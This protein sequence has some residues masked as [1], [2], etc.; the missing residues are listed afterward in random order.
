MSYEKF[1]CEIYIEYSIYYKR[2]NFFFIYIFLKVKE[3][4]FIV[5]KFSVF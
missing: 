5:F 3:G 2:L 1:I 4:I